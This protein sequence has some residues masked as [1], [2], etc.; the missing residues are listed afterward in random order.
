[1]SNLSLVKGVAGAELSGNTILVT[2][3]ADLLAGAL[4][5]AK[6]EWISVQSSR[7]LYAPDP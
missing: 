5:M 7:E 3:I 1:V 2:G 6:G 4:S